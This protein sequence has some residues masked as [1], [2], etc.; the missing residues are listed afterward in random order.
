MR[1]KPVCIRR[2]AG[3]ATDHPRA[4]GANNFQSV[5]CW[6]ARGSSPRVRGKHDRSE[7][8]LARWRIIPAC[9][10]QTAVVNVLAYDEPDH[11]RVCGANS[12]SVSHMV[13]NP[14]SSPRVRGKQL[15]RRCSRPLIRIIPACAGQTRSA[16]WCWTRRT[17][18]P[19]VCGANPLF[20]AAAIAES[21]SS[22]RVR[23]KPYETALAPEWIRIIP[24][25]AGQTPC[26]A[27]GG[28][29]HADH[30]RVCGANVLK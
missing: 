22:P 13:T 30:P 6:Y 12:M 7:A 16:W 29:H 11:P 8:G 1:G 10:G 14:G 15:L 20:H 26:L 4:C 25:C 19:R 2:A 3:R 24:A 28:H 9:A 23:G 5:I 17:D 27:V 21:G 18:H